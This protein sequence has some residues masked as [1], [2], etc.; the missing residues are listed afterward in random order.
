[1]HASEGAIDLKSALEASGS[2]LV[3]Y[4]AGTL[5]VERAGRYL[6][7]LGVDDGV[8]VS[9]DGRAVYTRDEARPVRED[10]DIVTLDLTA[11]DHDV[12]LKLH[13]R[14]GAWAFRARIVDATLGVPLG[15]YVK[16]PGTN[17]DDAR[18][19]ASAMSLVSIDRVF[20]A[21]SDPPRYRP[22]L[23]V[24][25]AEGAPRGVPL[26]VNARLAKADE[27]IFDVQAGGVPV[28]ASGAGELVVTL[29]S[30]APPG[31]TASLDVVVAGRAI[32]A[33]FPSRPA[34]EQALVRATRALAKTPDSASWLAPAS[35]VSV[36]YL[37]KRLAGL[38]ARGDLD[39]EAQADEAREL[40][41]LAAALEAS[42]DPYARA[43][44]PMRRAMSSSADGEPTEFGLYVPPWYKPDSK[45]KFP[46][47]VALHGLN[48]YAMGMMRWLFGGD[49]PKK[50]QAWEDRHVGTLPPV[51]AFVVTP[52]AHGN[53]L[54][55]ELG[56]TDV[57][58]VVR[59]AMKTYPIDE[60]RVTITGP[61]MGGIG[62]ASIPFHFPNVFAAAMPLCGYHSYLIRRDVAGHPIR[63]WERFLAEERSNVLWA[64]NGEHL[65]LFIVHGTEDKPEENSGVLIERYEK[66]NFS[67]KHEHPDAGHNVWQQTYEDLAGIKW[68]L[69]RQM[70]AHPAH[71]RFKTTRTRW[72]SSAWLSVDELAKESGWADVDAR[73]KGK[74]R[75]TLTSSG[76]SAITLRR[77]DAL[78]DPGAITVVADGQTLAFDASEP[79]ALHRDD[80]GWKKG[81]AEH[82][83]PYKHG[84][85][86]GPLRDVFYDSILFVYA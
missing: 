75:V 53:T 15:E 7:L 54:Y 27:T 43:T 14:D 20:D 50:D 4:A 37:T 44:G 29:P 77:D 66:L 31:A 1:M 86:T 74:T 38:V 57:M 35:R 80:A 9:I 64:E 78:F 21:S 17:A 71:V 42:T 32:H 8:R 59:W 82:A 5:H 84:S 61:S 48:G 23:T 58:D 68:L 81:P 2:D 73:V 51:D 34:T 3:A 30:I 62:S 13:Q 16:L 85:V 18:T 70:N 46:L 6:L 76:A 19:L 28:G 60:T 55:R 12:L 11:G 40:D 63:P 26:P 83:T 41:R 65:P 69:R 36:E 72:G 67:I 39:L 47:I 10:D 79:L 22:K 24:R 56:E 33:S 45:R 52:Q 25:Y 49:D